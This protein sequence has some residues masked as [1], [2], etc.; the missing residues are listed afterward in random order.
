MPRLLWPS[1]RWIT[2]SGTPSC[3]ISTA[4]AWRSWW[5][6]KRRR[7]PACTASRLSEVRAAAGGRSF[8]DAQQC[9]DGQLDADCQPPLEMLPGPG[10]HPDLASLAAFAA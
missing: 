10:V 4:W 7:T 5:G 9:A 3:A 2:M 1:W 8:Y 6:A